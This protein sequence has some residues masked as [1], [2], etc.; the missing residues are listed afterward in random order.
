MLRLLL[1]WFPLLLLC[2]APFAGSG[3]LFAPLVRQHEFRGDAQPNPVRSAIAFDRLGRLFIAVANGIWVDDGH[4][5]KLIK[6]ATGSAITA[7]AYDEPTN[8]LFFGGPGEFGSIDLS[9]YT[10]FPKKELRGKLPDTERS[11]ASIERI[12]VLRDGSS[13]RNT[14]SEVAFYG[15]NGLYV[16]GLEKQA[17]QK[18]VSIAPHEFQGAFELNNKVFMLAPPKAQGDLLRYN[19]NKNF[20][21]PSDNLWQLSELKNKRLLCAVPINKYTAFVAV[22]SKDGKT[23]LLKF[24]D[25]WFRPL[26]NF[27]QN[28]VLP[29]GG[30]L[31]GKQLLLATEKRGVLVLN[32]ETGGL[33]QRFSTFS[34][35]PENAVTAIHLDAQARLWTV[36]P[37]TYAHSYVGL[38]LSDFGP[39]SGNVNAMILFDNR[40]HL[41]TDDGLYAVNTAGIRV[42]DQLINNLLG[43]GRRFRGRDETVSRIAVTTGLKPYERINLAVGKN[44]TF[45][46]ND[47]ARWNDRLLVATAE[48]L[49]VY[50]GKK[51][52]RD[53]ELPLTRI[54]PSLKRKNV[55]YAANRDIFYVLYFDAKKKD[56]QILNGDG[57]Q[58]NAPINSIVED[59]A[60]RVWLGTSKGVEILRYGNALNELRGK[61]DREPVLL[62]KQPLNSPATVLYADGKAKL[63]VLTQQGFY[64]P[65]SETSNRLH[66]LN[67]PNL[68]G[69]AQLLHGY[70]STWWL[71]AGQNLHRLNGNDLN[72][73]APYSNFP[74]LTERLNRLYVAPTGDVWLAA[75]KRV[76]RYKPPQKPS[77]LRAERLRLRI[78]EVD[79]QGEPL[80]GDKTTR[81]SVDKALELAYGNDYALVLT[82][83]APE[84]TAPENLRFRYALVHEGETPEPNDWK[85][86]DYRLQLS[87]LPYGR[88]VVH[89]QAVSQLGAY[90][91]VAKYRFSVQAPFWANTWAWALYIVLGVGLVLGSGQIRSRA[92]RNRA[93]KLE[94]AVQERTREIEHQKAE[95]E[96]AYQQL[97]ASKELLVEQEKLAG[98]GMIM[99]NVAHELNTPL[100]AIKGAAQNTSSAL[101][102]SLSKLA[103]LFHYLPDE[104]ANRLLELVHTAL[105]SQ[106]F[107]STREQR[108]HA[109]QLEATLQTKGVPNAEELAEK[110]TRAGLQDSILEHEDL[111]RR[112]DA[113]ALVDIAVQM[114]QLG[115]N[116][117]NIVTS[118][119]KTQKIV[120]ALK[121]AA[122]KGAQK[123]SQEL[124]ALV[125]TLNTVLDLYQGYFKSGVEVIKNFHVRPKL[126][127]YADEITQVWTNIIVNAV[128]AMEGQGTLTLTLEDADPNVRV[129]LHN[130]G[131]Q[132]PPDFLEKIF[133]PL[134]TTKP[135]GEGTGLG[136]HIC[137]TIVEKH[138]GTIRV[139]N[140]PNDVAFVIELP[141]KGVLRST[142]TATRA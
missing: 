134:F 139:H 70:G 89:V 81:P 57:L 46:C 93:R 73:T 114:A 90:S 79:L 53:I 38:P 62:D 127:L 108:Q 94:A 85:S 52:N 91:N 37:E 78:T 87:P 133:S 29:V 12:F 137:K 115:K 117:R 22:R 136:L 40:L 20:D 112:P 32:A 142:S 113:P 125:D 118:S 61:P 126:P 55:F 132:I 120:F 67:V 49:W 106:G 75:K 41:A 110:L 42:E 64:E 76:Y 4:A 77:P 99:S 33:Q 2:L 15:P 107:Q 16:F 140:E 50:S 59:P 83:R 119:E 24:Q 3:Q 63:V 58:V 27:S 111:L 28:D 30:V 39:T 129:T 72:A 71:L 104:E 43:R 80:L 123:E 122:Y 138:N 19:G 31:H 130:T 131:P 10:R 128:Q 102:E 54:Q 86:T 13:A 26:V 6:S 124:T 101:P 21:Y 141:K 68:K 36:H 65:T 11:K 116:V 23:D 48:G 100:A 105:I 17:Y 56:W 47:L 8:T 82:L 45:L 84:F 109:R 88:W 96:T 35:L 51:A 1:S 60:R 9:D 44:Q 97:E 74:V 5:P 98:L 25:K 7:L 121:N 34:G 18:T 69:A 92:L 14:V 95:L 66:S 103:N 135:K